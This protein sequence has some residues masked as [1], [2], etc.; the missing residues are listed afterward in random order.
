MT[1]IFPAPSEN[2][3][4]K[5]S[6]VLASLTRGDRSHLTLRDMIEAFGE[7]AFG[8]MLLLLALMALF[9][10]PPGGKALFS[11]PIILI[12]A[13]MVFQKSSVWLPRSLLDRKLSRA[14]YARLLGA[15]LALPR[16]MRR[17]LMTGKRRGF[18]GWVNRN[19]AATPSKPNPLS[20]IRTAERLT[21]PRFPALSGHLAVSLIGVACIL[22]AFMMA[23][24]VPF[25]DMLPG[26][27]IALLGLG[28]TQRDG[29]FVLIGT[30]FAGASAVY[31]LLVWKTVAAIFTGL[32]SWFMHLLG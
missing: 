26:L 14:T 2:P 23:L 31:M 25:G 28:L 18:R 13:E 6:D 15:P 5:F 12:S 24:P 30:A 29:G 21:R 10:W 17:R 8:A 4:R 3:P 27:A 7:R 11:V 9:P 1:L 22:L 32:G 20:V 16:W 19:L